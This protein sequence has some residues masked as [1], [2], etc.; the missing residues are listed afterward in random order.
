MK[1]DLYLLL[2]MLALALSSLPS[3]NLEKVIQGFMKIHDL[4]HCNIM[5]LDLI[6]ID[7]AGKKRPK[8]TFMCEI[9]IL[10][11][12]RHPWLCS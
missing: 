5:A 7:E 6:E 3:K 2:S 8:Y 9:H 1:L 12:L 10:F 11:L 4:P